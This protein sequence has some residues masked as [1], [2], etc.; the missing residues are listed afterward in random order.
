M[1]RYALTLV[2]FAVALIALGYATYSIAPPGSK[3]ITALYMSAGIGGLAVICAVLS[4]LI[5]G[6]RKLGMIGIHLGLIVPLLAT[7]AP[8]IR[9]FMSQETAITANTEIERVSTYLAADDAPVVRPE[10]SADEEER[11]WALVFSEGSPV[12]MNDLLRP[13]GYQAVGLAGTSLLGAFAFLV[14]LMQ[15]PKLPPKPAPA[16][17]A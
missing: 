1:I 7:V 15:R 11:T 9:F 17:T 4:L 3:A 8:G 6:N 10:V 16:E 5:K 13:K 14:L 12:E 2:F